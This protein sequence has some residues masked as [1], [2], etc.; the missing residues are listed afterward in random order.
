MIGGLLVGLGTFV[1]HLSYPYALVGGIAV[2]VHQPGFR[3]TEDLDAVVRAE[4]QQVLRDLRAVVAPGVRMISPRVELQD[5]TGLDLLEARRTEPRPGL[6]A[7][8]LAK[9]HAKRW[10]VET[11][12]VWEL[13][14]AGGDRHVEV[15]VARRAVLVAMKL[16]ALDDGAREASKRRTDQLDI[17]R[18]V[19]Q[20]AESL[21]L[22][23]DELDAAP[24]S[25]PDWCRARLE[26]LLV[27]D[28]AAFLAATA[29]MRG[30]PTNTRVVRELWE[31][32]TN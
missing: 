1:E 17:W 4:R 3:V 2:L 8:R 14:M 9:E 5:G 24:G 10:A 16:A 26:T 6:P 20:H 13:G 11:A 21:A 18:L 29:G 25:L 19:G 23:L 30:A 7:Q 31:A 22:V 12:E 15:R 32:V 28:L 27:D